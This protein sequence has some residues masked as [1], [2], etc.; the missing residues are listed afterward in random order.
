VH[1]LKILIYDFKNLLGVMPTESRWNDYTGTFGY[2]SS[3]LIMNK[4]IPIVLIET[5]NEQN[6]GI[7][8][9]K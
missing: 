8:S 2:H 7:F 4:F 3:F 9:Q 5:R 6:E 1:D